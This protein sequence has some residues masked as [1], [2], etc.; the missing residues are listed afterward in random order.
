MPLN[1]FKLTLWTKSK[2]HS[3]IFVKQIALC[4]FLLVALSGLAQAQ[5]PDT[6]LG[7][8]HRFSLNDCIGYA[9]IN[10]H[11]V[12]NAILN[13]RL[14]QEKIKEST[15][16]LFP[17]ANINGSFIDNLKL[18]TSLI[19]D[20][21]SGDLNNKIPVQMGSK[22]TSNVFGQIN[23]TIFNSN[24][25]VGLQASKVF[26]SLSERNIEATAVNISVMVTKAY[27]NVLVNK[28][29]ITIAASNLDQIGKSLK[30]IKARYEAGVSETIDVNRIQV[31]YNNAATGIENQQALLNLSVEQLKFQMGMPLSDSLV[32]TEGIDD[33]SSTGLTAMDT[34]NFDP[35]Q[36]PEYQMQEITNQ[37]NELDLKSERLS[38]LPTVSTYLNYGFNYFSN[39]LGTL[40]G[41][42]FGSAAFGIN[43]AFPIFSGGERLH[44][45]NQ[46]K[47]ILEQSRNDLANLGQDIRLQVKEAYVQF[48]NNR[49]S[50]QTQKANMELTQ[51]VYERVQYKFN[52]GVASSLDLLSAENELQL[53]QNRYIDALLN[54]LMSRVDLQQALG[55]INYTLR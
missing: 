47:I 21:A 44:R 13:N 53:A 54:A 38:N 25:F 55:K 17:H 51:G 12:R 33:F 52:S 27:Y 45:I 39:K 24:Y 48:L 19:P 22:F 28:E 43:L 10:Q 9:L 6:A 31:Q 29:A 32:L 42:G 36:R 18:Q 23:Q 35:G 50:L 7:H 16:K 40:Y 4:I 2:N 30:D 46:S 49:R 20:F 34:L 14:S 5:Q 41:N 15:A 3:E 8:I 26:Q 11:E 37:L 1:F